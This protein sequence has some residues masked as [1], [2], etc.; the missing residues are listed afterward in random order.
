MP[1]PRPLPRP[2]PS[3]R[4]AQLAKLTRRGEYLELLDSMGQPNIDWV[5]IRMAQQSYIELLHHE[6]DQRLRLMVLAASRPMLCQWV[7]PLLPLHRCR[8]PGPGG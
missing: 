6:L 2:H 1:A 5:L 8:T 3:A 7:T 4:R